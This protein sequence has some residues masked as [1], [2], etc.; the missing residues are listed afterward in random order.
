[1]ITPSRSLSALS[2]AFFSI[3]LFNIDSFITDNKDINL[4]ISNDIIDIAKSIDRIN[5][6]NLLFSIPHEYI[7]IIDTKPY[8]SFALNFL[9]PDMTPFPEREMFRLGI[10][11]ENVANISIHPD[12]ITLDRFFEKL[13]IE[14]NLRTKD[15]EAGLKEIIDKYPWMINSG[16][17]VRNFVGEFHEQKVYILCDE[18]HNHGVLPRCH[19]QVQREEYHIDFN[20]ALSSLPKWKEIIS[21]SID[22]LNLHSKFGDNNVR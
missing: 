18:T 11:W 8:H 10:K 14:G 15:F 5:V 2:S 20:V 12:V 7:Q 13:E 4:N 17:N 3:M 16:V 1:M 22:Y 6:N 9:L 19:F 21:L